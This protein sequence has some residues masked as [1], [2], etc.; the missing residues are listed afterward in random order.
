MNF[1]AT[2]DELLKLGAISEEQARRSLD[3]LDTLE[4]NKP[5]VGQAGR[6][7]VLGGA[8]GAAIGG[9]G[10][11]IEQGTV[12]K[13][14]TPK[15]KALSLASGAVKGVLAGGALPLAR[16]HLDRRAELSTLRKYMQEN[17]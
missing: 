1:S 17:Q 13:G 15:E 11:L 5:T 12:L 7:G 9:I 8:T 3:R 6:Y 10:N 4:H 16:S 2:L 14:A